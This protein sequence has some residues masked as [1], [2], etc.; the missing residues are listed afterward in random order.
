MPRGGRRTV[1]HQVS[2]S[3]AFDF[4]HRLFHECDTSLDVA[5]VSG[6]TP[7]Q[8]A[9]ASYF[10][11]LKKVCEL[12]DAFATR[13]VYTALGA[14]AW[15]VADR[16]GKTPLHYTIAVADDERFQKTH[17]LVMAGANASARDAEGNTPLHLAVARDRG[18][19]AGPVRVDA[20]ST[21]ARAVSDNLRIVL[22]LLKFWDLE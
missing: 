19:R 12:L 5:D 22:L 16:V 18:T 10:D 4:T 13:G 17:A 3:G 21:Q 11:G 7:M 14:A 9:V 20:G 15:D 6:K 2:L 8:Y 1:L